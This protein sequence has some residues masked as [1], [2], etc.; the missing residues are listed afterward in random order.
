VQPLLNRLESLKN[1]RANLREKL[2]DYQR[3]F[4]RNHNRRIRYRQDI[5]DVEEDYN[6]YKRLKEDIKNLEENVK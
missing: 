4:V 2:E 6:L 1:Q 5:I 3:E